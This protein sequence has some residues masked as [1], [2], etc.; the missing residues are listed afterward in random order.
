M[1]K[2]IISEW[3]PEQ[4]LTPYEGKFS[5]TLPSAEKHAFT[6]KELLSQIGGFDGCL[7]LDN[8][9]DKQLLDAGKNLKV[10]ANFGVGYDNIDWQYA[11][12]IG[13]PVVNTPTQVTEATA[14]HT[15]ALIVSAM[16]GIARYDQEVRSGIWKSPNFDDC[17]TQIEGATL[18]IL[19]FGRIGKRVCRKAQGFGMKVVYFD[20]FRAA[21]EVEKEYD[22][23][24]M[25]FDEVLKVSDCVTL[26]VPYIPENHHL[27]N[28][29]TFRKMKPGAYFVNCARGKIVDEQA[30]ADALRGGVIKGAALDV[31]EDEPNVNP[32]LL[33][34]TNV[35]LTPH[36]ASLTMK[37]RVG[38]CNEALAG[39]TG[40]LSGEK[41][42]NVVNPKVLK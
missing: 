42:Y 2:I 16:R 27:F 12:E 24:Y 21:P 36:I 19:G 8:N 20:K 40:V 11:T 4:C 18:G 25:D 6:Y 3:V 35:T 32:D 37:A 38:M 23:T 29:E 41:P 14:E 28:A 26:H 7:I 1:K 10:I 34:L 33:K 9:G 15:A 17:D 13:L 30:L 31:F 22:V 39:I 5:F